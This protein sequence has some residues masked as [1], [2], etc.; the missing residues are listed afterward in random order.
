M[1]NGAGDNDTLI[2]GSGGDSFDSGTGSD[3]LWGGTKTA[4]DANTTTDAATYAAGATVAW[5]EANGVWKVTDAGGTDTLHGIEK[6]VIGTATYWLVDDTANG[7]LSTIQMPSP[8]GDTILISEAPYGLHRRQ[9]CHP[10]R[11][12]RHADPIRHAGCRQHHGHH[13]TRPHCARA[14]VIAWGLTASRS[15]T[16]V[17]AIR[18]AH[19]CGK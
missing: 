10:R 16:Q 18:P 3:T 8:P 19:G 1:I 14:R 15:R 4:D 17:A 12:R 6:V 5:D 9:G 13:L 7:G 2:G 11:R